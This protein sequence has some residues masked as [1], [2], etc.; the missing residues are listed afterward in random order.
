VSRT[1]IAAVLAVEAGVAANDAQAVDVANGNYFVNRPGTLLHVKNTNAATRTV[2][3]TPQGAGPN[4]VLYAPR[5]ITIAALT[6][7][8]YIQA[9]PQVFNG[10]S[11]DCNVDVSVALNVTLGVIQ[12]Q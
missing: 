8:I 6:G 4:G 10:G 5:V 11:A 12:T 9:L 3:L 1:L 2:T 7:D